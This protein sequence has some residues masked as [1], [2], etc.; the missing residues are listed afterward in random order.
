MSPR[1]K[2]LTTGQVAA[3]AKVCKQKVQQ[4]Y[5]FGVLKGYK[6]PSGYRRF[7]AADVVE[8]FH[9]NGIPVSTELLA[10]AGVSAATES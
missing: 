4:W 9:A 7:E 1:I 2:S 6:L 3:Y 5:D 10:E 8:F